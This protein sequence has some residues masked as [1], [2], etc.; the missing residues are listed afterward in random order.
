MSETAAEKPAFRDAMRWRR[1]LVPADGF[2]PM[3]EERTEGET[4]TSVWRMVASLRSQ[5]F[6]NDGNRRSTQR[7]RAAAAISA[8]LKQANVN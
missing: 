4:T 1:C 3:E 5:C 7:Q 6:G 8:G 2:D